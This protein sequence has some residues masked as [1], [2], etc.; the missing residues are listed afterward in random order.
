VDGALGVFV[1][2]TVGQ[3]GG[4]LVVGKHPLRRLEQRGEQPRL[5]W[6]QLQRDAINVQASTGHIEADPSVDQRAV[7]IRYDS[8]A[9]PHGPFG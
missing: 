8:P 3:G 1:Y 6:T 4:Q 9:P 2:V 5:R 7:G